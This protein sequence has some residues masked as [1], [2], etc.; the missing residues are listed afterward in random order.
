[1]GKGNAL[2]RAR[3]GIAQLPDMEK[4]LNAG[5]TFRD[6]QKRSIL[7][8]LRVLKAPAAPLPA[9]IFIWL[10]LGLGGSCNVKA[11]LKSIAHPFIV[12]FEVPLPSQG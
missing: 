12:S 10:C 11:I 6:K 5:N 4:H 2:I 8:G 9:N 3:K 7:A 1:M